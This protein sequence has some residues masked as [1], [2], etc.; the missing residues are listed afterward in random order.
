MLDPELLKE[1]K[2]IVSQEKKRDIEQSLNIAIKNQ[3]I[4]EIQ[5]YLDHAKLL[6]VDLDENLLFN[7]ENS[8]QV[9]F[10]LASYHLFIFIESFICF[11]DSF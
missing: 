7:A 6:S 5:Y 9:S 11:I 4:T 10:C 3:S 8:L 1:A 2:R